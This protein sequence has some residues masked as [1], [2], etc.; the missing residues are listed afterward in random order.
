AAF[1]GLDA[2]V[3][4]GTASQRHSRRIRARDRWRRVA[5]RAERLRYCATSPL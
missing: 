5:L 3:G 2:A 4:N 1:P